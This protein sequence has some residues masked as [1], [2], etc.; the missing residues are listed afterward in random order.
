MSNENDT[1]A[2]PKYNFFLS[3][4]GGALLETIIRTACIT[5]P[6]LIP[7]VGAVGIVVGGVIAV[8]I[9]YWR[10]SSFFR[11]KSKEF[12]NVSGKE[13]AELLGKPVESLKAEDVKL[14]ALPV[15]K[16]GLGIPMIADWLEKSHT[17]SK[18]RASATGITAITVA[19]LTLASTIEPLASLVTSVPL[20]RA[21][22]TGGAFTFLHQVLL[23]Q[24]VQKAFPPDT[25]NPLGDVMKM[26]A[27]LRKEGLK[28]EQLMT[29]FVQQREGLDA[30]VEQAFGL[31]YNQL[32]LAVKRQAIELFEPQLKIQALT[33]A[34]NKGEIS[35]GMLMFLPSGK[36]YELAELKRYEQLAPLPAPEKVKTPLTVEPSRV[37]EQNPS[38]SFSHFINA[39]RLT[40]DI[41]TEGR[42]IH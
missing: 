29:L 36:H 18:I 37:V 35:Q 14:A 40:P 6:V 13:L 5:A 15:E 11:E 31:P 10:N 1:D 42:S 33:L 34:L 3:R 41:P 9:D 30:S 7:G 12:L 25:P 21:F 20:L 24:G 38:R 19:G 27:I 8:A 2:K 16:G 26:Q 23:T 22:F 39:Q 32:P 4:E 28:P 17:A